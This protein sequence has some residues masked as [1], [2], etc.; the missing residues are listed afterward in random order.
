MSKRATGASDD[1]DSGAKVLLE[2]ARQIND[3]D[4]MTEE[5]RYRENDFED[6]ERENRSRKTKRAK[7][8]SKFRNFE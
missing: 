3:R 1:K 7:P 8:R 4:T 2:S 6:D 5:Q